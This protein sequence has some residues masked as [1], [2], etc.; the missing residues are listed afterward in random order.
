VLLEEELRAQSSELRKRRRF[1]SC[2]RYGRG[3]GWGTPVSGN[4][5]EKQKSPTLGVRLF[6]FFYSKFRISG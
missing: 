4:F 1:P 5:K 6:L 2:P 3:P